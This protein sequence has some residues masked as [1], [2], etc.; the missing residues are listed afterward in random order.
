MKRLVARQWD[1]WDVE[2]GDGPSPIA[3]PE[4]AYGVW[5]KSGLVAE[6]RWTKR[7][8]WFRHMKTIPSEQFPERVL[9]LMA[10]E[11]VTV[12]LASAVTD[13]A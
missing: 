1:D 3:E 4:R 8:G 5:W 6:V 11:A 2:E 12:L 7:R 13:H 9:A 10:P